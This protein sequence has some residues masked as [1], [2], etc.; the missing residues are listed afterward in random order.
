M[1]MSRFWKSAIRIPSLRGAK[2]LVIALGVFLWLIPASTP[3]GA[4]PFLPACQAEPPPSTGWGVLWFPQEAELALRAGRELLARPDFPAAACYLG[5]AEAAYADDPQFHLDLGEAYW[6]AG[7]QRRA[8]AEWERALA[9]SPDLA[10]LPERLWKGYFEAGQW[11]DAERAI[12]RWLSLDGEDL[13]AEYSLALIRAARNPGSAL[14]LLDGL[15]TAPAPIAENA[16]TLAAAI[17][18]ALARRIPE[19]IFA[20]TGEALLHLG[21]SRLAKEALLLAVE[22]NPKYGEA[23]ALLGLAQE[24]SGEDPEASYRRGVALAPDS[25][26]ACMVFGAWLRR[27]GELTLARW[28]L[29]QAWAAQPGDWI[30]ADELARVDFAAGRIGEAEGWVLDAVEA[31]PSEAD[32]WIVLAAFYIENDLRVEESGLPAARQAVLLA[33]GNDQA[34]DMLGMAWFK[35]GDFSAAERMFL[36]ALKQNP[37]SAS[38]HLHL[39]MC[40][41]QQG[42]A[43]E[44]RAEW[45]AALALDANGSIGLRAKEL[46]AE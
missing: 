3:H 32:A 7:E 17:R 33:P 25:A 28:W 10:G 45:E 6:G 36:R 23:F 22:R 41:A 42:R 2:L 27:K 5:L 43:G 46:I 14:D 30:I 12:E 37:R 8:L 11:D 26:I 40:Y 16:R 35:L 19:Y 44:A 21:E 9:L 24:A 29:V 13:Q 20:M 39:G 38:A 1:G 31:N 4:I 18:T 15:K 34:L